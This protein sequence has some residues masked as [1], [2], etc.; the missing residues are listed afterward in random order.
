MVRLLHVL[1]GCLDLKKQIHASRMYSLSLVQCNKP[2]LLYYHRKHRELSLKHLYAEKMCKPFASK[3]DV[4]Q[5]FST[6]AKIDKV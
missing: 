2:T 4:H 6:E 5:K 3:V 1:K